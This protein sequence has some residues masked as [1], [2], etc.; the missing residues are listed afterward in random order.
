[1]KFYTDADE[2]LS[3]EE[4]GVRWECKKCGE[5]T[6]TLQLQSQDGECLCGGRSFI[7]RGRIR[8]V[9]KSSGVLLN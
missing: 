6:R 7:R 2:Y 3:K 9:D 8:A 5:Y 4:D 1:M